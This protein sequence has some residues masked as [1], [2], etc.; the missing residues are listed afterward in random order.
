LSDRKLTAAASTPPAV[1]AGAIGNVL[2]WY[3]FAIYGYFAAA[4]GRTYFPDQDP[5]AQVLSASA[6]CRGFPDAPRRRALIGR[7]ADRFERRAALTFSVMAMAI[8]TFLVGALPGYQTL[9]V[10]PRSCSSCCAWP[11]ASRSRRIHHLHRL[12]GRAR[13][14]VA[15]VWSAPWPVAARA[16]GFLLGAAT[17]TAINTMMSP[18]ALAEW[19]WRI[20]FLLGLVVG[21]VGFVLRRNVPEAPRKA[22]AAVRR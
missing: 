14:R 8:P 1:A 9:G 13:R 3:D 16:P 6:F 20:P 17:A 21:L 4:I 18:E 2:E 15:E 10:M 12:H 19:G 5:V 7:I 22:M 11:R